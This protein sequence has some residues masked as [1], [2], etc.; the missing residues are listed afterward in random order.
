MT[1]GAGIGAVHNWVKAYHESGMAALQVRN[2]NAAQNGKTAPAPRRSRNA[3]DGNDDAEALRRRIEE[4]EPRNALMREVV[5]VR[6]KDLGTDPR[7]L[8]NRE[9]T[10]PSDRMHPT[11]SLNSMRIGIL[12]EDNAGKHSCS[13]NLLPYF[14]Q[15]ACI[16]E[17]T[18]ES[19]E[20]QYQWLL[21]RGPN[22]S[23]RFLTGNSTFHQEKNTNQR[24][25]LPRRISS[26]ACAPTISIKQMLSSFTWH[27]S[28]ILFSAAPHSK[29]SARKYRSLLQPHQL[30]DC[31]NPF[32][33]LLPATPRKAKSKFD[34]HIRRHRQAMQPY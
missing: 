1:T 34:Q 19:Q 16:G 31:K 10:L 4:L 8:S 5:E 18:S 14:W 32:N 12:R 26:D 24:V 6:R 3:G 21:H 29:N 7:R 2:R 30:S 13:P 17:C 27:L 11:Y 20:D 23:R 33:T 25:A 22:S 9:K 15:N 28:K